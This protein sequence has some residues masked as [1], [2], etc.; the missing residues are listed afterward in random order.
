MV[1][2]LVALAVAGALAAAVL[3]SA[4][5]A[6]RA[7]STEHDMRQIE[8]LLV[9]GADAA[10]ARAETGDMRAWE[11]LVAPTEL[12]GSGSARLAVAPAP[13]SASELTL[14]VEYPLEGPIT[15]RRSRTV[16]LPST[17]AS[18]REESSP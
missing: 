8:R 9:A 6:R 18:N 13:S 15:I 4:L 2:A 14:V 7:L 11:L 16:V 12:A 3:R 17:S 10:R 5:L 1:L